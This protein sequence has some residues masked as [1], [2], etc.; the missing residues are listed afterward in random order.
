MK[1]GYYLELLT[2]KIMKLLGS[3]RKSQKKDKNVESGNDEIVLIHSNIFSNDY[4]Q[5]SRVLH[6]LVLNK[7]FSQLLDISSKKICF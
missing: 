4:Q 7:S 1:T 5:D 3:I 2:F 6:V